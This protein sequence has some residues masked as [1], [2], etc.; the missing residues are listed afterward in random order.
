M[1][2]AQT[3]S[4]NSA[5][6]LGAGSFLPQG[7]AYAWPPA[8]TRTFEPI[9]YPEASG[10]PEL[11]GTG[12]PQH[13]PSQEPHLTQRLSHSSTTHETIGPHPESL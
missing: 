2:Q 4:E 5:F 6:L 10:S 13:T 1:T 11:P 12:R 7:A 8:S 3:G 9:L